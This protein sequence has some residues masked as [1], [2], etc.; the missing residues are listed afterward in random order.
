MIVLVDTWLIGLDAWII[1][2][3]N[4]PDFSTGQVAE[5][6]VEFY[7]RQGLEVMTSASRPLARHLR[8][9]HYS[10]EGQVRCDDEDALVID[11]GIGVFR[12]TTQEHFPVGTMVA[13]EVYLGIDPFFYFERLAKLRKDPPLIYTWK[14][15]R[16]Q[17]QT[18][19]FIRSGNGLI[20]DVSQ[21][22]WADI[23]STDAWS[24]DEGNGSYLL[25][26]QL[27]PLDPKYS[28]ATAT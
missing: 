22:N 11:V 24:D 21:S 16:I 14:I 8:D 9:S 13:G 27:Q 15:Q 7:S 19:P 23:E 2:D 18:A 1:Q 26:C 5:F 25:E 4:Y 3:G 17:R 10:I 28:S 12:E 20:R 6:A